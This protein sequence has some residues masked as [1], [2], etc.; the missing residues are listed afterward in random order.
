[1]NHIDLF[2]GIGGFALAAQ[3]AGFTTSQFVEIDPFCQKVLAKNFKGVPIHGDIRTFSGFHF[4]GECDLLTGGFP[5]QP[6]SQAGKRL[7]KE[8]DRFLWDEMLRVIREIKPR[9]VCGENV[10]GLLTM[11]I[12]DMLS[13]LEKERY[14]TRTVIIPAC[15][16]SAPHRRDRVWIIAHSDNIQRERLQCKGDR[17]GEPQEQARSKFRVGE[18]WQD[19][20]PCLLRGNHGLPKGLDVTN[21]IKA[22]GNAIVPQV[23]YQILK[24]IYDDCADLFFKGLDTG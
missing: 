3:W 23:A 24:A 21:R 15:A 17:A 7:G 13:D 16:V 1:M 10:T 4:R 14:I 2:S 12:D 6:F 20:E 11:G 8:D 22:L 9:W 19:V 5:C 18:H